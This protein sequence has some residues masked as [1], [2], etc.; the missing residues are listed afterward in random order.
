MLWLQTVKICYLIYIVVIW[1]SRMLNRLNCKFTLNKNHVL[2]GLYLLGY[3]SDT[4]LLSFTLHYPGEGCFTVTKWFAFYQKIITLLWSFHAWIY[5]FASYI[6]LNF[7]ND[8]YQFDA[9]HK[10]Y[11]RR[12]CEEYKYL[13]IYSSNE[14]SSIL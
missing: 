4:L 7:N 12:S 9:L 2:K 8:E 14:Y 6:L 3:F 13:S 1:G 10:I 5:P 11:Y